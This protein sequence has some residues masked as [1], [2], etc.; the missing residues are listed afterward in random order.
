MYTQTS[1]GPIKSAAMKKFIVDVKSELVK[2]WAFNATKLNKDKAHVLIVYFYL[3]KL[4][5]SGWPKK[6]DN[7]F[8]RKDLTNMVKVLED[9]L[10]EVVGV[11]DSSTMDV[12][13]YKREDEQ[14]PRIEITIAEME[15]SDW[16]KP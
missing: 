7:R 6:A 16:M 13:L 14:N 11:D 15:D 8:V 12:H 10:A 2:Y 9:I 4:F 1:H 5:T 3:P